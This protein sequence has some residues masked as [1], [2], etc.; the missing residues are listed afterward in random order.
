MLGWSESLSEQQRTCSGRFIRHLLLKHEAYLRFVRIKWPVNFQ[1]EQQGEAGFCPETHPVRL[2]QVQFEV[3]MG[4]A[5][6]VL[7][8]TWQLILANGGGSR[9]N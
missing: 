6:V 8:G 7:E 1:N 9:Y 2:P 3:T 4:M 5:Q